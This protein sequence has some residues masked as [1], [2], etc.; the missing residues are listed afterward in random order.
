MRPIEDILADM[1]AIMSK[2]QGEWTAEDL[3]AYLALE[4][5]LAQAQ[6]A[7]A[8]EPT[9]AEGDGAGAE[10]NAPA[11]EPATAL[12]ES[13]RRAIVAARQRHAAYTAVT[14]PAG[15]PSSRGTRES[16]NDGFRAYLRTGQVNADLERYNAQ[17]TGTG[18]SGGYTV[19][20]DFRDRIVEVVKSFGGVL[21]DVETLLT[22]DG[23]PLPYP[24]IDDTAN[25]SAI[26]A[27]NT[28]PASAGADLVFGEVLLNAY[29]YNA[30]GASNEPLA[31]PRALVQD[32]AVDIEALVAR[33]LGLR[34]RRKMAYDAINGSAASEP[35]GLIDGITGLEVVGTTLA[36]SDLVALV[37]SL[38]AA[39]WAGAKFYCN[40]SALGTMTQ[41]EDTNGNLIFKQGVTVTDGS[42]TRVFPALA[43]G[44]LLVPVVP[45]NDMP[46]L[47]LTAGAGI[48]WGVFGDIRQGYIWRQVRDIEV[49]VDPYSANDKRQV[50]YNAWI[51]ADGA[52]QNT[53]A[54][55]VIAGHTT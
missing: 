15:R 16:V 8:A 37:M 46:A 30:T 29:E 34:L 42:Q 39:Y 6:A 7:G 51:R 35:E 20:E 21:G 1:Q 49:L 40:Q 31:L 18:S 32:S 4:V 45:D 38:D 23:R 41:I 43:I 44:A 3:T 54:Y 28:A 2:P 17:T 22:T 36:Y 53:A 47:T 50:K 12:S 9:P 14:V 13:Q 55:K 33:Q 48:N 26:A 52:Q 5:E 10:D 25:T 11:G 24:T 19:P 27:E